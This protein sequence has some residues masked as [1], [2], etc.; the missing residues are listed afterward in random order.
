M[1]L[2]RIAAIGDIHAE[3][4]LLEKAIDFCRSQVDQIV[5][6]GDIVDGTGDVNR[7]CV[8]L[9]ENKIPAVKGNHERWL[10]NNEMRLFADV[11]YLE[12][13]EKENLQWLRRL[14]STLV[15]QAMSG[16]ALLCHGLGENDMK[17][18]LPDENGYAL[19][20]NEE[21]NKLLRDCEYRYVIKGH[22]HRRMVRRL[23]GVTFINAGTLLQKHGPGFC[24][25]DFRKQQV[26]FFDFINFEITPR[27]AI[28]LP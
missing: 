20:S 25:I 13:I 8:L 28:R 21:L 19:S 17:T 24:I 2:K 3:D 9:R 12:D 4:E 16:K 23:E 27:D 1:T 15:L 11:H 7:C 5:T 10:L 26:Q 14:P 6:V 18:L 22:S